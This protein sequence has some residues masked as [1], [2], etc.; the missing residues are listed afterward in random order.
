VFGIQYDIESILKNVSNKHEQDLIRNIKASNDTVE[1]LSFQI[2]SLKKE[3][4]YRERM[5][6]EAHKS[7][8]ESQEFYSGNYIILNDSINKQ[9][10]D[11]LQL[12]NAI[13]TTLNQSKIKL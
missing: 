4:A 8:M 7:F 2:L 13:Q 3:V 5:L 9:K 11:N 1:E 10:E 6:K 12:R